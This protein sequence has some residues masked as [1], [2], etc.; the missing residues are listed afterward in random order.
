M[1]ADLFGARSAIWL[2]EKGVDLL[3]I[4][5]VSEYSGAPP[6]GTVWSSGLGWTR[7]KSP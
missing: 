1:V 7:S 3:G 2:I 5:P 4:P 6:N